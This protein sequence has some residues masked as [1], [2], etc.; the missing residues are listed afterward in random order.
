MNE[1]REIFW[2][3]FSIFIIILFNVVCLWCDVERSRELES[4]KEGKKVN[5]KRS[6]KE[7][8]DYSHFSLIIPHFHNRTKW[9]RMRSTKPNFQTL[10]LIH[11]IMFWIK[12]FKIF[13]FLLLWHLWFFIVNLLFSFIHFFEFIGSDGNEWIPLTLN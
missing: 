12:N 10:N 6:S 13:S 3:S 11:I 8:H 7:N 4:W 9:M 1:W 2:F 5:E